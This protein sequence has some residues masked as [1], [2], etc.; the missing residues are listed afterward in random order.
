MDSFGG[1][2]TQ[3]TS[4][5][6]RIPGVFE[7]FQQKK[8]EDGLQRQRQGRRCER[9]GCIESFLVFFFG[10]GNLQF[11]KFRHFCAFCWCK[12]VTVNGARPARHSCRDRSDGLYTLKLIKAQRSSS[13]CGAMSV[14][15]AADLEQISKCTAAL[16]MHQPWASHL[17]H[18]VKQTEGCVGKYA[19]FV[20]WVRPR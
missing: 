5:C 2:W 7:E 4:W 15:S 11:R 6:A 9:G 16:T 14:V 12:K 19:L 17:V 1:L 3:P 8:E 10:A 20:R 18:G 13:N